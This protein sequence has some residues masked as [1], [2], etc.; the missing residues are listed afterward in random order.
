VSEWAR[1]LLSKE[2]HKSKHKV[3]FL[4]N[5]YVEGREWL[6]TGAHTNHGGL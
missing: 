5:Y 3:E 4:G 6:M 1:G 2:D